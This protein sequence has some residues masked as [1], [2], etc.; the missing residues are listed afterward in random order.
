MIFKICVCE[1]GHGHIRRDM[2]FAEVE[3]E[4]LD[5][6]AAVQ[7]DMEKKKKKKLNMKPVVNYPRNKVSEKSVG[8]FF[9]QLNNKQGNSNSSKKSQ[10]PSFEDDVASDGDG[11]ALPIPGLKLSPLTLNLDLS[12]ITLNYKGTSNKAKKLTSAQ[13]SSNK[14]ED[15]WT[16]VSKGSA[17]RENKLDDLATNTF[18]E[19]N[20]KDSLL[21]ET[22]LHHTTETDKV[23]HSDDES[24]DM[25]VLQPSEASTEVLSAV[26]I[27][28]EYSKK[29]VEDDTENEL[30]RSELE[31]MLEELVEEKWV[32]ELSKKKA[33]DKVKYLVDHNQDLSN[34]LV[35]ERNKLQQSINFL[36]QSN[37]ELREVAETREA[38]LQKQLGE[39][40]TAL[41]DEVDARKVCLEQI[42]YLNNLYQGLQNDHARAVSVLESDR[43]KLEKE[44]IEATEMVKSHDKA[45][46]QM[47]QLENKKMLS[48]V[49]GMEAKVESF[50][51]IVNDLKKQ[52]EEISV[53]NFVSKENLVSEKKL[54]RNLKDQLEAERTA[55]KNE[56][57]TILETVLAVLKSNTRNGLSSTIFQQILREI[58]AHNNLEAADLTNLVGKFY[59]E[60]SDQSE[61]APPSS[62]CTRQSVF[63]STDKQFTNKECPWLMEMLETVRQE[64]TQTQDR[65]EM[66]EALVKNLQW[67]TMLMERKL[68]ISEEMDKSDSKEKRLMGMKTKIVDLV[69]D[70]S[71]FE[72]MSSEMACEQD[73]VEHQIDTINYGVDQQVLDNKTLREDLTR[74]EKKMEA[75]EEEVKV[76]KSKRQSWSAC[77]WL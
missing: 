16:T 6:A 20:S 7:P 46:S 14:D 8:T 35:T 13:T 4:R 61:I 29:V 58:E 73:V 63:S 30:S 72:E 28:N 77:M 74:M 40:Q 62:F 64:A 59:E 51:N 52:M 65:V 49:D 3:Q 67:K 21:S 76:D 19:N 26:N 47:V 69:Q 42:G 54:V 9:S 17:R 56:V 53:N 45:V 25:D 18:I 43:T 71:H 31:Q 37:M 10:K 50:N 32:E 70:F 44:M 5:G 1:C 38:A 60:K 68:T 23:F 34:A 36:Q 33:L 66:L 24:Y 2:E 57:K 27:R 41:L 75:F 39:Q 48:K 12:T 15:G 22:K 55:H 11:D